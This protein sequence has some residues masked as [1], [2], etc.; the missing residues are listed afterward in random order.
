MAEGRASPLDLGTSVPY[1]AIAMPT[2]AEVHLK[3]GREKP[4]AHRHP[5][6]FSG[7]IGRVDGSPAP[8]DIVRV[9]AANGEFLAYGYFNP[10]SQISLRLLSWD[11]EE[12]INGAWW[13]RMLQETVSRRSKLSSS[14]QTNAYRLVYS[15]ADGLPGLI[16]DRYADYLVCQ[17]LTA[18]VE[19][20]RP[21]V[22]DTL[23]ERL[24][25]AG[26]L[27]LSDN[28]IRKVE[29]LDACSGT[30]RGI[31]A[32]QLITVLENGFRFIVDLHSGQKTG[33]YL[34]QRNNRIRVSS[35]ASG[36]RVLDCFC[37]SGGFTIPVLAVGATHVTCIDSSAP[38]LALLRSNV[39][40]LAANYPDRAFGGVETLD[41]N[42]FE[43]L[44][45][46]RDQGR[47]FDMVI[48]DPPK[49]AASQSQIE[50]AMRAYKD[51]NLLAMRLL[52]ANGILAT[53]S[54]SG[55]VSRVLFQE[56][57][58]WAATDAKRRVQLVEQLSQA[59]DHPILV[60]FP[61]S[62]YLKGL[63]C[64]VL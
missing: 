45:K 13:E 60:S 48:L 23:W 33:F 2:T 24:H 6:L 63:I 52:T 19:K 28:D 43:A 18:G 41:A 31:A 37:Y 49:L 44:R 56:A 9:R 20:V 34:D 46:L 38:S 12:V 36:R 22:V 40:R 10:K 39:E 47:T 53:F 62:E 32:D 11:E 17:F 27:D 21:V 4:V 54:C 51:V 64:R 57:V 55:S 59:E 8:G 30:L 29:G 7:A 1:R 3:P 26:I 16:V 58:A 61:E 35:H 5:W 42:V 14:T 25:P 50:R 15:E